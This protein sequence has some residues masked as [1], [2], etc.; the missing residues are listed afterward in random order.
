[1]GDD[2]CWCSDLSGDRVGDRGI[3][4]IG[5]YLSNEKSEGRHFGKTVF[6]LFFFSGHNRALPYSQV[7][8]VDKNIRMFSSF[9]PYSVM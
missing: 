9:P 8:E 2:I 4:G 1:M 5:G 6:S 3:G 7:A